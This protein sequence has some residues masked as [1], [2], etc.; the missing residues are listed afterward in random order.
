M[1]DALLNQLNAFSVLDLTE[2][3]IYYQNL[4][5]KMPQ[6]LSQAASPTN[7]VIIHDSYVDQHSNQSHSR[8]R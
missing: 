2:M 5:A 7:H 1:Y 4:L 6:D 3:M 8:P